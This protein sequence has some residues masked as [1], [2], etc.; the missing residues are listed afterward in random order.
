M[1]W[2]ESIRKGGEIKANDKTGKEMREE[3]RKGKRDNAVKGT[4]ERKKTN[5]AAK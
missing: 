2:R 4:G 5:E 1:K 3:K